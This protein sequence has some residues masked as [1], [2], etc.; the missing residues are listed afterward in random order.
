MN[1]LE[2]RSAATLADDTLAELFTEAYA[3]YLVPFTVSAEALRF[4]REAHDDG[5]P[6]FYLGDTAWELFHRLTFDE[7]EHYLR[8][9]A[10]KG[11]TV[12]Q[13]VALAELDG[14]HTPNM[15]GGPRG[16]RHWAGQTTSTHPGSSSFLVTIFCPN[17]L[18]S[19]R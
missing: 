19:K 1:D 16:S 15:R 5:T 4:M 6:F 7:A 2:L 12:I 18:V 8:D 11:F 10:A 17:V 14:L 9:R 3:D 13:A